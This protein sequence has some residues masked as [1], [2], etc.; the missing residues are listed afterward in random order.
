VVFVEYDLIF[1]LKK[2]MPVYVIR[3]NLHLITKT[4]NSDYP[5]PN[6]V[7]TFVENEDL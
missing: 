2:R 7:P 4:Q 5:Y 1:G 6:S 3:A